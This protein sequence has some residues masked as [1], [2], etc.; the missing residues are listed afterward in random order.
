[1]ARSLDLPSS[2]SVLEGAKEKDG[3]IGLGHLVEDGREP[4]VGVVRPKVSQP[5]AAY[6]EG[7]G[8]GRRLTAFFGWVGSG[9]PQDT[10][11]CLD[12]LAENGIEW[13]EEQTFEDWWAAYLGPGGKGRPASLP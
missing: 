10:Q 9:T 6:G 8:N 1:M 2:H 13:A 3:Q 4:D 7:G 5:S 12:S 11:L